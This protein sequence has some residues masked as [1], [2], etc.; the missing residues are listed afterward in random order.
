[1]SHPAQAMVVHLTASQPGSYTG[2]IE[3]T[4]MHSGTITADGNHITCSGNLGAS[5]GRTTNQE[6]YESQVVVLNQGGKI[7]VEGNN[8][9]FTGCDAVTILLGAGTSY[10]LDYEKKYNGENPH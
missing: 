10:I 6:L 5:A 9:T 3:L 4:D 7:G 8:V 1:A 2:K